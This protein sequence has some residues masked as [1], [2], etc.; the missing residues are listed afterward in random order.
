MAKIAA[1]AAEVPTTKHC[2]NVAKI[3]K[4]RCDVDMFVIESRGSGVRVGGIC[5]GDK[6]LKKPST[7]ARDCRTFSSLN[8]FAAFSLVIQP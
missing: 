3:T 2:W 6:N 4:Q 7:L 8:V 5:L 1:L